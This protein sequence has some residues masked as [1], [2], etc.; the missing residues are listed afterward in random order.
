MTFPT[1]VQIATVTLANGAASPSAA[2]AELLTAVQ[3]L[4][5]ITAETNT[6]NNVV[7]LDSIGL[8]P[9]TAMPNDISPDN[10]LTLSP[11]TG[12][13]KIEDYLRLQILP[14]ATVLANV[15]MS[16]GD[17]ALVADDFTGANAKVCMYDGSVWKIITTLSTATTLT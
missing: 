17:I 8:L 15:N 1:G 11:G 13:V 7:V 9:P 10:N 6:A 5:A 2:R 4:N 16:I 12:I 14:K 3:T